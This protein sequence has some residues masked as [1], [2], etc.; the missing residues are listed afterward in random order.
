MALSQEESTK[1]RKIVDVLS[2]PQDSDEIWWAIG[3]IESIIKP[4]DIVIDGHNLSSITCP[5]CQ[6]KF[7]REEYAYGHD[8]EAN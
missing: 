5:E 8:C 1:L 2:S 3:E 6:V 4:K 7:T